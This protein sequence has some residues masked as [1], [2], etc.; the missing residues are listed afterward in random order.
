L[1][2][3]IVLSLLK[4]GLP[5]PHYHTSTT[6]QISKWVP[7]K[8][9]CRCKIHIALLFYYYVC[10]IIYFYNYYLFYNTGLFTIK[11]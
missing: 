9:L 8:L 10:H 7:I 5:L 11:Y 2:E 6:R 1:V 3:E 4:S